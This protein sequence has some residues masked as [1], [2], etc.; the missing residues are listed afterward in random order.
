M[1]ILI[2]NDDSIRSPV[3]APLAKW[4]QKLGEVTVV[5]PKFEQSGKSHS[6]EIH[7]PFEVLTVPDIVSGVRTLTVDSS[8]ADCV[9]YAILGMRERFDLVLSGINRG[10]NIGTDIV[11]S[12]TAGAAAEA[13]A[14]GCRAVALST[15]PE[16]FDS[17]LS[18][19]DTVLDFFVKHDLLSKNDLYNVNIPLAVKG[20]R[21]T[22]QGGPYYSDDFPSIGNDLVRPTGKC[23]YEEGHDYTVDTHAVLHG[24]I[25]ITP[26]AFE[27][28]AQDVFAQLSQLNPYSQ[29]T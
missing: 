5:V 17:A 6:I 13:V 4:A 8:P 10:L 28:T 3:L 12:G 24:Y 2:T 21:I 7:K 16:S 15:Q 29:S 18:H 19:L 23:I 14:L 11:Y 22:R 26:L 9:R 27:R 25:S 20:L 1:R